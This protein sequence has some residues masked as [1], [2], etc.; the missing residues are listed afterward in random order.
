MIISDEQLNKD[1]H[2]LIEENKELKNKCTNQKITIVGALE[3][4]E[5]ID[6]LLISFISDIEEKYDMHD[7][8]TI[9]AIEYFLKKTLIELDGKNKEFKL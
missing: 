9:T 5:A 3:D 7:F 1:I 2:T 4:I 8:F 6:S